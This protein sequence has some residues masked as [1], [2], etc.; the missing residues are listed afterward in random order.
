MQSM[1]RH[2]QRSLSRGSLNKSDTEE[3]TPQTPTTP[4]TLSAQLSA[5]W[6]EPSVWTIESEDEI[7]RSPPLSMSE[8]DQNTSFYAEAMVMENSLDLS[9]TVK[10]NQNLIDAVKNGKIHGALRALSSGADPDTSVTEEN[11]T[12]S[13][14]HLASRSNNFS[15]LSL[16]I[17]HGA[18]IE[19]ATRHYWTALHLAAHAGHVE[20]IKLLLKYKA[21]IDVQN[22]F[23]Q[24]PLM[25]AC[26]EDHHE[27]VA[28]LVRA[29]ADVDLVTKTKKTARD[30]A[31]SQRVR[32]LLASSG[33]L[34]SLHGPQKIELVLEKMEG[35]MAVFKDEIARYELLESQ[36]AK[37]DEEVDAMR[38][39]RDSFAKT[40]ETVCEER[41]TIQNELERLRRELTKTTQQLE[42]ETRE[43]GE[44]EGLLA[45]ER[46]GFAVTKQEL[47]DR[48]LTLEGEN[49][50]AKEKGELERQ[51]SATQLASLNEKFQK[52][53]TE[54]VNEQ[55]EDDDH[56][57]T[58]AAKIKE[59]K[60][61]DE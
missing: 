49:H 26:V 1:F 39:E 13:V 2:L 54:A 8:A 23:G 33:N 50:I 58:D 52:I 51:K 5:N 35:Q 19:L 21:C 15:V 27:S 30:L 4:N 53:L 41:D 59:K 18:S 57:L 34:N 29:G 12:L 55:N 28:V 32:A 24:T 22:Q 48:I 56:N 38:M 36:N 6:N 10:L 44:I 40:L 16:L 37:L 9:K 45:N 46:D 60:A 7:L 42:V 3:K 47:S 43:R 11:D 14:V 25:M 17:A 31:K 61:T 20:T